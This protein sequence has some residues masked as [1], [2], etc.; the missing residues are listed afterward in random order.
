MDALRPLVP[1]QMPAHECNENMRHTHTVLSDRQLVSFRCNCMAGQPRVQLGRTIPI[2]SVIHSGW[3]QG[4]RLQRTQFSRFERVGMGPHIESRTAN[5]AQACNADTHAQTRVHGAWI[6]V[7]ERIL[8]CCYQRSTAELP[9][10]KHVSRMTGLS[11]RRMH[12]KSQECEGP[13]RALL[14]AACPVS[15]PASNLPMWRTAVTSQQAML[16]LWQMLRACPAY[17]EHSGEDTTV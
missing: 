6:M 16:E 3:V 8:P 14:Q 17:Q 5:P 10:I 4:D 2:G 13:L 15:D 9:S 1:K 12:P 11:T 7:P